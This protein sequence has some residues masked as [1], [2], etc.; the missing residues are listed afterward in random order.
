MNKNF[1]IVWGRRQI[2]HEQL[3]WYLSSAIKQLKGM[4]IKACD[5]VVICD[6]NSV[7]SVILLL[8]LWQIKALAA[9]VNGHWPD[10]TIA[11]YAAKINAKH[12]FRAADVKRAVCFD[13][14]QPI[15]PKSYLDLDLE[16]KV[17]IIATSGSSGE[18]KAAVH[19][20]GNHYHS[21]LG[22]NAIIP[23]TDSDRW[24][25][26]LPLYHV[27]GIAVVSRCLLSGAA[28]VIPTG[29][30]LA[31]S[32]DSSRVTHVSL[33][34]T[35][36]HRL[37]ADEKN[38]ALLRSLKCIL[39][40][41]SAI[42]RTI[43]DQSS[44]LGLNVYLSYGLTEMSSQVATGRVTQKDSACV[45]VLPYRQLCISPEGEILVKGEVLFKGYVAGDKIY[46]PLKHEG[47]FATGDKGRLDS[48]GCLTVMGRCDNMFISGGEN[49]QPEEIERVLLGIP[50]IAQAVVVPKEDREF[51]ARPIAFIKCEGKDLSQE[52]LRQCLEKELPRFKIP[53]AFYPWPQDLISRGIKFSRREFLKDLPQRS[54]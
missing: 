33:V 50:G 38:Y 18:S 40:G 5:H 4:G 14:R 42:P 11:S 17:T 2:K 19:T 48:Q 8:A 43:I 51:G 6:E 39:L 25:L 22:S 9:F 41:G 1:S 10:K 34:S 7:E 53:T 37:L 15:D 12:V 26:S 45:K 31:A 21:A 44:K 23:L 54:F 35:Q 32:I 30:D 46:L 47:W 13:A 52:H 49:I 16:Q 27:S 24:L 20:W 29:E 3:S 28:M 36:L